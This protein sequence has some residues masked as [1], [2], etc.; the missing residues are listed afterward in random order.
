LLLDIPWVVTAAA[1]TT[2]YRGIAR[3]CVMQ[4]RCTSH[5]SLLPCGTDAACGLVGCPFR[6][7]TPA[8]LNGQLA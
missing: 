2:L 7:A 5:Q 1:V 4:N 6:T 8:I 3:F